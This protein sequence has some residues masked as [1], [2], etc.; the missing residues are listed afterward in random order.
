M[1]QGESNGW[2]YAYS[3]EGSGKPVVLLHGL[4]MDRSMFDHQ[5]EALRDSYRVVTIDAP[6][7]GESAPVPVGIDFYRY[8]DMV[9]GVADQLNVGP[10]VWGGQSMGGF[11]ILRLALQQPDRVKGLMLIDTQAHSEDPDKLAQY[12]AFLT[13]SLDQGVSEDLVNILMLVFFSQTYA[14]KPE[15]DVWRKKLLAV[16]V[17][18]A[19]AMIRAVFDRDDI[20]GRLGEITAPAVVIHGEEDMAIELERGEELARDLPD[21]TFAPIADAGHASCWEAPEPATKAITT[22]LKRIGY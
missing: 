10:A 17:P 22:F 12:E 9:A 13:V 11:T 7:H 5:V 6:G 3:D 14:N 4:E 21:A 18:G 15:S 16:D 1:P 8:A 20:D 19:H 2:Q